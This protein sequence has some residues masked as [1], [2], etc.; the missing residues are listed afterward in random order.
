MS[1]HKL[2]LRYERLLFFSAPLTAACFLVLFVA[3]GSDQQVERKL[4]KCLKSAVVA[5]KENASTL[6]ESYSGKDVAIRGDKIGSYLLALRYVLIPVEINTRC[7]AFFS[8]SDSKS[9]DWSKPPIDLIKS[10]DLRIVALEK[11]P[12]SFF[13]IEVPERA[14]ISVF[15]TPIKLD[16]NT[17][18]IFLQLALGPMLLLWLGS[19]YNTRNRETLFNSR[20]NELSG[21]YPHLVNVYPVLLGERAAGFRTPS[22]KDWV[23]YVLDKYGVSILFAVTRVVLLLIFILPPVGAY[24]SSLFYTVTDGYGYLNL[25]A[26][27]IIFVFAF[28]NVGAEFTPWHFNKRFAVLI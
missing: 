19:I 24:I 20:A 3:L 2:G 21:L 8:I 16:L 12:L 10:I 18:V 6:D 7:E 1:T 4:A 22:K 26:G 5:I 14:T 11:Q 13:G 9:K 28:M 27:G 25:L 23:R 17:L 15:G